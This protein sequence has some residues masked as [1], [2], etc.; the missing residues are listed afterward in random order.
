MTHQDYELIAM[1]QMAEWRIR[2]KLYKESP[3]LDSVLFDS[4]SRGLRRSDWREVVDNLI[5]TGV[6]VAGESDKNRLTLTLA[7]PEQIH[8]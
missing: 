7:Q 1:K 4:C 5:A 8:V 6:L 3:L 2:K